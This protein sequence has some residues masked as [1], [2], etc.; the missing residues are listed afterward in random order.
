MNQVLADEAQQA[1]IAAW[2]YI[3]AGG[4][5]LT[6]L[7]AVFLRIMAVTQLIRSGKGGLQ[8]MEVD[9]NEP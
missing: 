7:A 1:N 2:A 5:E 4:G 6:V 9:G 3:L 8:M